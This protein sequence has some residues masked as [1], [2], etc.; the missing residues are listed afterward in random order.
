MSS[1]K[2]RWLRLGPPPYGRSACGRTDK[3][4][5]RVGLSTSRIRD[6]STPRWSTI[7]QKKAG[8]SAHT[9]NTSGWRGSTTL[10]AAMRMLKSATLWPKWA[11]IGPHQM[12]MPAGSTD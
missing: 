10:E 12:P 1:I 8:G 11:A 9:L 6:R 5:K 2:A 3:R 4:A 7:C